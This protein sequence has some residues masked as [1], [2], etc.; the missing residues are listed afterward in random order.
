MGRS[1]NA[2]TLRKPSKCGVI[3]EGEGHWPKTLRKILQKARYLGVLRT[4]QKNK[5]EGARAK[6]KRIN[7]NACRVT[8]QGDVCCR[9]TQKIL[10]VSLLEIY[11]DLL[12]VCG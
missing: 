2:C 4:P 3:Q 7:R 8:I 12:V 11:G 6:V 1:G 10:V 9:K 5:E